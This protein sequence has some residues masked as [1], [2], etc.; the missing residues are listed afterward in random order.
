MTATARAAGRPAKAAPPIG[1]GELHDSLVAANELARLKR[2]AKATGCTTQELATD[3]GKGVDLPRLLD[4]M[5]SRGYT[6]DEPKRPSQQLYLS[7]GLEVWTVDISICGTR[8]T[9]AFRV[10]APQKKSTN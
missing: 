7:R 3:S 2:V 6:V 10:P 9:V 4:A 1:H 8:A 5:R